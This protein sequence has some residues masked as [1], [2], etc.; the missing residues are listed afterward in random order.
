MDLSQPQEAETFSTEVNPTPKRKRYTAAVKLRIIEEADT[1]TAPGELAAF[2]RR[3][4]I[5]FST[6]A[7][8]RKQKARGDLDG[9]SAKAKAK[10]RQEPKEERRDP[11]VLQELAA[12]EREVRRLRRELERARAMLDLQKK[13]W[14]VMGLSLQPTE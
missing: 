11:K 6:L 12:S 7:D 1:Y 13:V 14:E 9:K 2:L 4:G 5:Y 10:Q 3:E 8:F